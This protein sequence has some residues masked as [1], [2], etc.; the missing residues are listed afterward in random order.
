MVGNI[1]TP[2]LTWGNPSDVKA[3]CREIIDDLSPGGNFVLSPGCEFPPNAAFENA[4][5]IVEVAGEYAV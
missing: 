2:V 1:S 4:E 3:H 5:A